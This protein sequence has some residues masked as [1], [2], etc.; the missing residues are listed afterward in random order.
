MRRMH[1]TLAIL[2]AAFRCAVAILFAAAE[3]LTVPE[4]T[5]GGTLF[6]TN[7]AGDGS[8]SGTIGEY[9]TSGTPV[10][11]SLITGLTGPS[12]IAVSGSNL[13]VANFGNAT[14]GEYTTSGTTVNASLITGLVE[15]SGIAVS[16]SNLFIS[17]LVGTGGISEYTT[18]GTTVNVP[19]ITG[20]GEPFGIAMSGSDLF[21]VNGAGG[22]IGEYT[23]SGTPVNP[24]LITGLSTPTGIAVSGSNLFIANYGSGTIGEYT[25]SG[26]PVKVP[27]ITGLSGPHGIAVDGP[28]LYVANL[29]S[30]TIGEYTTSGTTVNASLVS[31]LSGPNGIAVV[32]EPAMPMS[33]VPVGNPGNA[34]DT[35]TNCYSANCG[36]VPYSYYISKY[37]T[38]NAQYAAFLNAVDPGG[39]NTLGLWNSNMQTDTSNGGISFV[40]GNPSGSKY[41]VNSGFGNYPVVY[42]SFYDA[43]RFANWL[44]N[45]QGNSSTETGA[46]TLLGG[47]PTP[48]NGGTV[49][50]NPGAVTVL[51]SEN[52][53]YKA[54]YYNPN[55][56]EYLAYPTG[57]NIST[58]CAMPGT[59]V[60]TANCSPGGPGQVTSV[61]AY[62]G[63]AN[64]YG[65]F[66]QGGNVY[67][68]NEQIV[69]G[70][71]RGLRG[72]SWDDNAT[73]L[74]ASFP[75]SSFPGHE[76][77]NFGFRVATLAPDTDGDGIP[78]PFDNCP[79]TYN[80]DQK[81]SGGVGA[82]SP[83][84]GI[85]D[86]CQCGDVTGDG[87]VDISDKTILS[88][89]LAG[90]S[91][92][93]SVAAMPGFDKC[94]VVDTSGTCTV[95]DKTV[96]TRA[97]AGL[98]PGIKQV[99]IAAI[100]HSPEVMS[101]VTCPVLP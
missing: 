37:D 89:S 53:W 99:C 20:L 87:I 81:D 66:D 21:V 26:T 97:V 2:P 19:L 61:G 77:A 28:L 10:N 50:R 65:T 101:G 24:S 38:T 59:T 78:D 74:A 75:G 49:T 67:Q 36:S 5:R 11:A 48:S 46:Y 1:H 83:P 94:D 73:V 91:P 51:P 82:G 31:G 98:P 58:V 9:T 12:G 57:T 13:F 29:I 55:T 93:A 95:S 79:Y 7:Y 68:W 92:Y 60:N 22:T 100:C 85:G 23:T 30:G 27:L 90:L 33:W 32:P 17:Y 16:G 52:E 15:P 41:V 69:S 18:S 64:P 80:P 42:V 14:I 40:S 25:T 8:G 43:L 96:I 3:I 39:S 76:F 34:A 84:D 35:A 6:E 54:A 72:G 86:A 63:S 71:N 4:T 56:Q 45:G 62:T 88:R 44:N 47:T 70:S